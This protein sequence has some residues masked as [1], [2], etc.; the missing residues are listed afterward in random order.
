MGVGCSNLDELKFEALYNDK[1]NILAN[2]GD[3]YRLNYPMM[4]L[5]KVGIGMK[6]GKIDIVNRGT[7]IPIGEIVRRGFEKWSV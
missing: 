4:V 7:E 1:V 5:N 2:Q 6:V 3:I